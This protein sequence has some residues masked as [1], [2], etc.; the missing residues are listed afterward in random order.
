[1]ALSREPAL[2]ARKAR[3]PS[4]L[5]SYRFAPDAV[6]CL[7][8]VGLCGASLRDGDDLYGAFESPRKA[9]NAL[10]RIAARHR[11][12]HSIIGLPED[13]CEACAGAGPD[14]VPMR[15]GTGRLTHLTRAFSG[16]RSLRVPP[17]PY[18]GP[19]G[20]RERRDV[21]RFRSVAIPGNGAE[22]IGNSRRARNARAGI[23]RQGISAAR[24]DP[25]AAAAAT[26][27]AA[28][29]VT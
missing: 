9:Q 29:V 17:W 27:C 14:Q 18:H 21:V 12:C 1:M 3:V 22:L 19:I 24:E 7:S 23:R 8:L 4:A 5:H 16:L 11:L 13:S 20:V 10:R 25:A 15:T 26:G 2:P 28:R 6:P